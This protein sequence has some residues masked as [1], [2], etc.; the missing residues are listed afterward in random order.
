MNGHADLNEKL[1]VFG[2]SH[3]RRSDLT[4]SCVHGTVPYFFVW[5]SKCYY[6]VLFNIERF[7]TNNRELLREIVARDRPIACLIVHTI[8]LFSNGCQNGCEHCGP[9]LANL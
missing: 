7:S 5:E 4:E 3:G 2:G 8:E 6:K 9:W 1:F